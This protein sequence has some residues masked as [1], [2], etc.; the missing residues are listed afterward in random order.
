VI[1]PSLAA[2]SLAAD[3]TLPA[4]T[5]ILVT[6]T[7]APDGYPIAGFAWLLMYERLDANRALQTR[8]QAIE[9]LRFVLWAITDG[10]DLAELLSFARI[11]DAVLALNLD[12]IRQMTWQGEAVGAQVLA[13]AGY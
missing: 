9:L 3:V 13:E 8:E 11:P 1:E 2:T 4:D 6:D 5:R 10:Q 12:M 7:D